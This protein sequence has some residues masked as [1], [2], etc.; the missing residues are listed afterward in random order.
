MSHFQGEDLIVINI[1]DLKI[2]GQVEIQNARINRFRNGLRQHGVMSDLGFREFET[3]KYRYPANIKI[4]SRSITITSSDSFVRTF[5]RRVPELDTRLK[6]CS[7]IW[8]DSE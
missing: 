3:L 5:E 8:N 2:H 4:E 7:I 1:H 6:A